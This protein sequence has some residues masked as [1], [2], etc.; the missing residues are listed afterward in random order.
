MVVS[1]L[2]LHLGNSKLH[3]GFDGTGGQGNVTLTYDEF[4]FF[5]LLAF[6]DPDGSLRSAMR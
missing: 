2:W 5:P 4:V 6:E 3:G 1:D